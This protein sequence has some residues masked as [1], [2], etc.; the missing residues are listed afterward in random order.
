M[1][2]LHEEMKDIR[3]E[4]GIT[5]D[6]IYR[7]TKIRL[8]LLEQIETG[9]FSFVPKPYLRAFLREY[10]QVIGVDPDRIMDRFDN[11]ID[12]IRD[13]HPVTET[14]Q[15]A[16]MES[17]DADAPESGSNAGATTTYSGDDHLEDAEAAPPMPESTSDT[18]TTGEDDV[19]EEDGP[20]TQQDVD[21]GQLPEDIGVADVED[22]TESDD[23]ETDDTET[24]DT[25]TDETETDET[26]PD[27][28]DIDPDTAEEPEESGE[29]PIDRQPSLFDPPVSDTT[30]PSPDEIEPEPVESSNPLDESDLSTFTPVP[31]EQPSDAAIDIQP[32]RQNER[33]P[34]D[35]PDPSPAGTVFF[36]AFFLLILA[37]AAVIIWLN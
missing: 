28:T 4:R 3:D 26:T 31:P 12:S 8:H 22:D 36:A 25:E 19:A 21:D 18:V 15:S 24:D 9:D 11:R 37:A 10:A 17:P 1:K 20:D 13:P 7:V 2:P 16:S 35:L 27:E 14:D 33:I 32:D 34:L 6:D 29:E 5:L 23:T 30:D